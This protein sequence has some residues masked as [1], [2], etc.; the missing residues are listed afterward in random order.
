MGYRV[1]PDEVVSVLHASGE[2][3]EAAVVGEPDAQWG[4]VIVAHVVLGPDGSLTR[5]QAYC[6]RELPRYLRP[7][8]ITVR[9]TIPLTANGKPDFSALRQKAAAV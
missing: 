9:D 4:A 8:R 2:V 3:A 5:L 6:N 1:S 7:S